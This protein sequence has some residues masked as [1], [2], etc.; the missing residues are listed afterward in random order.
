MH[1]LDGSITV[2]GGSVNGTRA[3]LDTR[4]RAALEGRQSDT[5]NGARASG[6]RGWNPSGVRSDRAST[7][8]RPRRQGSSSAQASSRGPAGPEG[9]S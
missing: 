5:S 8:E 2:P 6:H 7:R 9:L 1:A 3:A 4:S